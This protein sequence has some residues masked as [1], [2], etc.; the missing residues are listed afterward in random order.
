[1]AKELGWTNDVED[2][3]T[4]NSAERFPNLDH[5]LS[6]LLKARSVASEQD[7]VVVAPNDDTTNPNDTP[8]NL[9]VWRGRIMDRPFEYDPNYEIPNY[10]KTKDEERFLDEAL[11]KNF[12]FATL[13]ETELQKL[14]GSMERQ[15]VST[16]TKVIEQGS[17]TGD[18]FYVVES[19]KIIFVKDTEEVGSCMSGGSFGELALLYS[20]PRA[21]SCLAA[22]PW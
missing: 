15:V 5:Q 2:T 13:N 18:F 9:N 21:V 14:I 12:I 10:P 6:I 3:T 8:E 17:T 16:G 1:M 11:Q 19:G 22:E 4:E 7:D 20:T